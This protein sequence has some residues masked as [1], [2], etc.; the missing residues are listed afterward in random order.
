MSNG[1]RTSI[2]TGLFDELVCRGAGFVQIVNGPDP[3][4][5]VVG[6]AEAQDRVRIRTRGMRVVIAFRIGADP[7]RAMTE[8]RGRPGVVVTVDSI[9]RI[10]VQGFCTVRLGSEDHPL[11]LGETTLI[12]GGVGIVSGNVSADRLIVRNRGHGQVQLAGDVQWL[13]I[14][15]RGIRT[16]DCSELVAQRAKA[17]VSNVGKIDLMVLD[18]LSARVDGIGGVTYRGDPI[19]YRRGGGMG[20]LDKVT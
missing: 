2:S 1:N 14:I 5:Q 11:T 13:D 18:E 16:L 12:H 17:T 8:S 20:R 3:S 4:V 7:L 19:V 9:S 15:N 10:H 6:S